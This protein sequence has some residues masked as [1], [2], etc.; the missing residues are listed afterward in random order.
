MKFP[1]LA[2]VLLLCGIIAYNS[3]RHRNILQKQ[4]DEFW[5]KEREANSTRRKP[6]D[7]LELISIPESLPTDLCTENSQIKECIDTIMELKDEPIANL[8]GISNTDLKLEYGAPNITLLSAYD[9]RYTTL[10]NTLQRW[11]KELYELNHID[12]ALQV[13]EFAVSTRTD[14]SGTYRLL[15]KIY[16]ER[17]DIQSIRKLIPIAEKIN[18][19]LKTSIINSLNE[20]LI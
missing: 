16:S 15:A 20:Y 10:A 17:N 2:S 9:Q 1:I 12:E 19:P 4:E 3:H 13:L 5:E 7:N 8:T 14:V 6:L 11:A 18:S